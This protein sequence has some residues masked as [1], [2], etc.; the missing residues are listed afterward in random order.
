MVGVGIGST[1]LHGNP[2]VFDCVHLIRELQHDTTYA[3]SCMTRG[4]SA[5][6]PRS[7]SRNA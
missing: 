5:R 4:A 6:P 3:K 7:S 2:G 1:P